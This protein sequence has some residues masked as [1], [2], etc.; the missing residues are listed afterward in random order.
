MSK[1]LNA[2]TLIELLVVIAIIAILAAILFPVFAQAKAA[3]KKT[4]SLSNSKQE[5]LGTIMYG[6][7]FD[8]NIP[9]VTAWQNDGAYIFFDKGCIPWTQLVY[10]YTKN[11]DIL[12]DPQAPPPV[13]LPPGWNVNVGKWMVPNYG[14]NPYLIQASS[15]PYSTTTPPLTPKN[16][17]SINRVADTVLL[18]QKNSSSET[19]SKSFY[20]GYWYGSGTFLVSLISDPPDCAATGNIQYC[21]GGWGAGSFWRDVEGLSEAAGGWTGNGSLRNTKQMV[22]SFADGHVASKSA[23]ALAEGTAYTGAKDVNGNASQSQTAIAITDITKEH[24]YGH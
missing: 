13:P 18:T 10:P 15:Y 17:S 6:G 14:I 1:R 5:T 24:Y 8:D 21:T 2:F 4:A 3:A 23:G 22:A 7:D 12:V 20:G 16:F 19:T 9:I 11:T